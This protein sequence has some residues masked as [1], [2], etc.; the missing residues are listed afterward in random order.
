MDSSTTRR[1]FIA[2]VAALAGGGWLALHHP[3]IVELAEG[4][5]AASQQR[6]PFRT[7]T[8]AEART[9]EALAEQILPADAASPG[10]KD[11]GAVHFADHALSSFFG[12]WLPPI[13]VGLADLDARARSRRRGVTSFAD[14]TFDEQRRIVRQV[15]GTAFFGL[16]RSL[17]VMGTFAEPSLGGN[18][19]GAR[20]KIL[21]VEHRPAFQ[22]P[23]GYYDAEDA[24]ERG[25]P[26]E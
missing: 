10:A 21:G 6:A 9:M 14:L 15:E 4:A 8:P 5:R 19:G 18:Q 2:E 3:I 23:F 24:R 25:T 16:A 1:D 13:R 11:A 20:E 22:P 12:D 7:L 17:A 26:G